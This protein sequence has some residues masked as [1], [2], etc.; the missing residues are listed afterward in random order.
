MALNVS[1][2]AK[3]TFI[4]WFLKHYQLKQ[5]E[6]VWL[7]NYLLTSE[8]L[9]S[10]VHFTENA[11]YCPK[12]IV[13]STVETEGLPF[14]LFDGAMMSADPEKAFELLKHVETDVYIQLIFFAKQ[15]PIEYQLVVED[16]PY[17][18][19]NKPVRTFEQHMTQTSSGYTISKHNEEQLRERIDQALD[20]G[21]KETFVKLV[22]Q[23][24]NLF[25]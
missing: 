22:Q 14:R 11:D 25:K 19:Q 5:R 7:L 16:N 3:K 1:N 24:N 21:D 18:K 8:E 17:H 2:A 6:G 13:M 20:A 10:R 12:A 9:I 15:M 4:K 23:L